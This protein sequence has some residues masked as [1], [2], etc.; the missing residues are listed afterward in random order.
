MKIF[1]TD[2]LKLAAALVSAG[3]HVI[4]HKDCNG[5]DVYHVDEIIREGKRTVVVELEPEAHGVKADAV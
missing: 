1:T 5:L 4:T 3:F 2:N